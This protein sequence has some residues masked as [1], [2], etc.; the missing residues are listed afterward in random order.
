[1]AITREDARE[2]LMARGMESADRRL[3][4]STAILTDM[5]LLL[6]LWNAALRLVLLIGG[7]AAL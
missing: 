1:M 5:A 4:W 7:W 2:N 6:L 3:P